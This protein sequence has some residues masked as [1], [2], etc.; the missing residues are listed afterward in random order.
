MSQSL[1]RAMV[2]A[3]PRDRRRLRALVEAWFGLRVVD[4]VWA[5]GSTPPLDYL[6]HALGLSPQSPSA[7]AG[8]GELNRDCVVW[9]SR[10]AGKTVL[11]ALATV[12]EMVF[13]P[14]VQVRVL[15]GSLEQ[16]GKV[17]EHLVALL[18]RPMMRPVV[19]GV[20]T[21]RR[22]GL[23]NGSR[24][25]LLAGSQRSV[26]GVR[27]HRLR[28]DEV[29]E[30]EPEVWAAAQHVTRSG[31]V[32][33]KR[34]VGSI[35]AL[36][37]MHRAGGLMSG[38]VGGSPQNPSASV[39]FGGAGGRRTVF[40]WTGMDVAARCPAELP[41]AGCVLWDD[42]GGVLKG[43]SGFVPVEDLMR[44]R[45]RSSDAAWSAE[46]MCRRPSVSDL[47]YPGFE[48]ERHVVE[49]Q[50]FGER[51]AVR[52]GGMDFGIREAAVVLWG[53]ADGGGIDGK[54]HIEGEL[55]VKD[56]TLEQV[57]RQ[58]DERLDGQG[59]EWV[60]VDP[61]GGARSAQSGLTDLDVLRGLG[62]RPR[63][64]R[65]R[66][67]VGIE[68]VRRRLDRGLLT[69]HPRCTG[70]IA[71]LQTYHFDRD[72]PGREEP[73]KDGPDHAADALRY[74]VMNL[75]SGGEGLKVRGYR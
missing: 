7:S 30:L 24:V 33:V 51:G 32:G 35:E 57:V 65:S 6:A 46:V 56:Q 28:V 26:R 25:E 8:L 21:L 11:A 9:A 12:L 52:V 5:A 38:L 43:A 23:V 15:G 37:T 61:A 16:A 72:R 36:S 27:V 29:D 13:V 49:A 4:R 71:A 55:I 64:R 58:V 45:E 18:D 69:V 59:L 41:Y 20:P 19:A 70:L 39:G 10:G 42:C 47:V 14:G 66:V 67:A 40:R 68:R 53:W 34:V 1:M 2:R 62:W 22:V 44:Q 48:R 73:V 31:V 3:E 63:A 17:H 54:L 50:P 74:L 60:G 75:E